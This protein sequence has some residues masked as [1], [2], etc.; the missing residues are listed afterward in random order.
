MKLLLA[1]ARRP[2]V[3]IAFDAVVERYDYPELYPLILAYIPPP[4]LFLAQKLYPH[5]ANHP[6]TIT[7][8]STVG[9][10]R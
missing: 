2:P 9:A 4:Q 8:F 5:I 10:V 1:V 6:S 3:G 7:T